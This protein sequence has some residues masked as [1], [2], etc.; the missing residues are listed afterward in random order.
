MPNQ[1]TDEDRRKVREHHRNKALT[2]KAGRKS[3]QH[4]VATLDRAEL[5]AMMEQR[6]N[7]I[8]AEALDGTNYKLMTAANELQTAWREL[9]LRGTQLEL[10][11]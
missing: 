1:Y 11:L 4:R 2:R 7:T 3:V 10:E 9:Q 8:Y 5:L 6:I